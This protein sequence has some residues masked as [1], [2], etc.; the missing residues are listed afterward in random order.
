M[1]LDVAFSIVLTALALAGL[2]FNVYIVLALIA[3]KEVSG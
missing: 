3:T 1:L 2:L